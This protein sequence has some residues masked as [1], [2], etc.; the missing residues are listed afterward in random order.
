MKY[1]TLIFSILI[2]TIYSC[3]APEARKP[4]SAKS[5]SFIDESVQRNKKLSQY[6]ESLIKK[7]IKNDTMHTY[8]SS[9]SGFWYRYQQR[10]TINVVMPRFGDIVNFDY[11]IK[12]LNKNSIYTKEELKNTTYAIDKEE[13]F[14][15]LREGLK[16]MKVGEKVTFL[17]PSYQAYGYYGDANKIGTNIPLMVNVTLNAIQKEEQTI[18]N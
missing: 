9:T 11:D 4:V 17:F 10:D 1:Y 13:L 16:L 12:D 15:G 14:Y 5:G 8:L 3:K 18:T 6:E 7:I 2:T